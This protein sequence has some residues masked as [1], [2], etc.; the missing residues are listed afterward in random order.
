MNNRTKYTE[1]FKKEAIELITEQG[2]SISKAANHLG[3]GITTL[4]N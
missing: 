4:G 1:E 3:I 2:Y